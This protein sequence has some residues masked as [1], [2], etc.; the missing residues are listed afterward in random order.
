MSSALLLVGVGLFS[1]WNLLTI[2]VDG[3]VARLGVAIKTNALVLAGYSLVGVYV[4]ADV[5]TVY[6]WVV[7]PLIFTLIRCDR[8]Q[9]IGVIHAISLITAFGVWKFYAIGVSD[10]WEELVYLQTTLRPEEESIARIGDVLLSGGYQGAN[11]DAANILVMCSLFYLCRAMSLG[12][13]KVALYLAIFS[14]LFSVVLLT[15]SAANITVLIIVAGIA[16]TIYIKRSL[17]NALVLVSAI[18]LFYLFERIFYPGDNIFVFLEKFVPQTEM[19]GGGIWNS[20]NFGSIADSVIAI[21]FGFGSVLGVPLI[22]SEAAFVKLLVGYGVVPFLILM[23]IIFSPMYYLYV[24]KRGTGNLAFRSLDG[25]S[26]VVTEQF[27]K[28]ESSQLRRL[29][30]DAIP[31]LGGALTLLH[32]GSLFRVTSIGLFCVLMALFYKEYIGY[33]SRLKNS[34]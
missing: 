24:A 11:H 29:S 20:L 23:F 7:F 15:G 19:E 26:I 12:G 4:S 31:L 32:Y 8:E 5:S 27:S 1:L 6:Q 17:R 3:A 10:G 16:G 2:E 21:F 30:F 33:T 28:G 9:L 25:N 14:L 34:G 13:I 18:I 22:Y